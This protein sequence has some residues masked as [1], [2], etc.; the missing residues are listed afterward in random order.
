MQSDRPNKAGRYK[1]EN[2]LSGL[3]A[4]GKAQ[5][6]EG[7]DTS[8]WHQGHCSENWRFAVRQSCA[9]GKELFRPMCSC[10]VWI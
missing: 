1:E 9:D 2:W 10:D 3:F 5:G 4:F 8:D 7:N 6:V